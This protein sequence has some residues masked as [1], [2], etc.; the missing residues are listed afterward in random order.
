MSFQPLQL[1]MPALSDHLASLSVAHF[2]P[3]ELVRWSC[4]TDS[5]YDQPGMAPAFSRSIITRTKIQSELDCLSHKANLKGIVSG[6]DKTLRRPRKGR[7]R[8]RGRP[9]ISSVLQ[10]LLHPCGSGYKTERLCIVAT[11]VHLGFD[12]FSTELRKKGNNDLS[13][14]I[15]LR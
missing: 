9:T 4:S 12:H 2:S 14:G 11:K 10:A 13:R 8:A 6:G 1:C 15:A 7:N 5:L 3:T